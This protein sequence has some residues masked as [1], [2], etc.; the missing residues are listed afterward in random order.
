MCSIMMIYFN[1]QSKAVCEYYFI[2][3]VHPAVD[4]KD[5]VLNNF[6]FSNLLG[7]VIF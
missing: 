6:T 4:E 2:Y 7:L 5:A 1:V 3:S